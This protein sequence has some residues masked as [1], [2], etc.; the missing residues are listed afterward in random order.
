MK[1]GILSYNQARHKRSITLKS[2]LYCPALGQALFKESHNES[3]GGHNT[4]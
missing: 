1:R 4:G 2:I 3:E